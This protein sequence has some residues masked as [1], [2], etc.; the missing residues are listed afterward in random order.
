MGYG[1]VNCQSPRTIFQRKINFMFAKPNMLRPSYLL[2]MLLLPTLLLPTAVNAEEFQITPYLGYRIGGEFEHYATGTTLK[3]DE[4][5]AYGIIFGKAG[6][7]SLEFIYSVQPTK[8]NARGPVTS[9]E[10]FDVDIINIMVASKKVLNPENGT[11]V[12]GMIGVTHFDPDE[13][14]LSSDTRFALGASAGLEHRITKGLSFRLEGRAIG[15]LLD[16][17]GGIFCSSSGGCGIAAGGDALFQFE[18][19]TGFSFRF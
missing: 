13:A 14:R 12:S 10:L 11:F 3:L 8:L 5:D 2:T 16:A 1:I 9:S 7:D 17:G 18:F 15:T 4:G 19:I 6:E